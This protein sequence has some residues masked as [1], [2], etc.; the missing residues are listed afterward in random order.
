MTVE[1][2]MDLF[3][4][5]FANLR[6]F[7]ERAL[8]QVND[9]DFFSAPGP[10]DNSLAVLVKHMA[11]N[12]RSRWRDFLSTDG[13]KPDRDRDGE[14]EIAEG[15]SR[16]V[17]MAAWEKGWGHLF[18][19]L[20]P[21]IDDDLART[22]TIRKERFTVLQAVQRQMSH[23]AF[24]VGQIV[25]LAKHFAGDDWKSLTIPKGESKNFNATPKSYLRP[26]SS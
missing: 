4:R 8:E 18:A 11:G 6:R 26:E 14:F 19:A 12:M 15:A 16:G 22:V 9:E 1:N 7:A 25:F 5:E 20:D 23:Y 10:A 17:L 3:R 2:Q 13:E 21:L 24:H